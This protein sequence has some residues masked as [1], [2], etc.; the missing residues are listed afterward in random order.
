MCGIC[1]I[2]NYKTKEPV[3]HSLVRN[4]AETMI[5]RGPDD[6]GLFFDDAHGVGLGFRRLSII[7]LSKAGS[8]PMSNENGSV[9]L[10]FNGEIYNF[11]ELRQRLKGKGH[12]FH[13]YTDSEVIIH[14]YE[15]IGAECLQDF[16]GMFAFVIWDSQHNRFMLARDRIGKKP[17]YYYDN[18]YQLIIASEL[19]AILSNPSVPREIDTD[20]LN[21]YLSLGY[22]PS[23]WTIFKSV[24]KLPPAH[25]MIFENCQA[26]I[27]R[28][29]DLLPAFRPNNIVK[30]DEWIEQLLIML[31]RVVRDRLI[32]DVPLG[33]FLSGGV[34]SS[35]IVALM[36]EISNRPVKTFSIGFKNH[37]SSELPYARLVAE[38]FETEHYEHNMDIES[39]RD[40]LPKIAS[41][42]DEPFADSS[43][44]PTYYVSKIARQ[45]VTV[46]LSGD[47]GDEVF[48][49][50]S[51][52][53]KEMLESNIDRVPLILRSFLFSLISK[54]LPVGM[55]G[56]HFAFRMTLSH[57]ERYISHLCLLPVKLKNY[58]L[59]PDILHK[60][61]MN[62]TAYLRNVVE[63]AGKMDHLS[64]MQYIDIMT[65]LPEDILVK[66]DR[67][68]MINSL[69]LRCPLLDHRLMEFVA[70]IPPRLLFYH[71]QQKYLLKKAMQSFLPENILHRPKVGFELPLND[72]FMG[73]LLE[74]SKEI[75]LDGQTKKLSLY[76]SDNLEKFL[77]K[78]EK[79]NNV[80]YSLWMFLILQM[81]GLN[82]L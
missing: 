40:L 1:A 69:E 76:Q 55:R 48:A 58:I 68:S 72:W 45:N 61:T 33:A 4:M 57:N 35:A 53:A 59:S 21:L 13:S 60:S 34:D 41:Q 63:H 11:L 31:R 42:F 73:D 32:S 37:K 78:C 66:V 30:E 67:M 70:T 71:G 19:K 25:F 62:G 49:G 82:Y 17:L 56:Q 65:Y 20:G 22:V 8:Q 39:V 7:D 47:G 29:W 3:N 2:W 77:K 54:V 80:P 51:R 43:M 81:W 64:R 18:G 26:T 27:K 74:F 23:P 14:H 6:D 44:L 79:E 5:H 9:R 75:L 24:H 16:V 36:A 46:C 52:Y 28:Y 15:D 12:L 50:Y 38:Q 10:V